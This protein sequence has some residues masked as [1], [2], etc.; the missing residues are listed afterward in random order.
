MSPAAQARAR[1]AYPGVTV[2][3]IAME[4]I[5]SPQIDAIAIVSPV[6]NPL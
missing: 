5:T 1:K 3:A 6:W 4:V 2:T